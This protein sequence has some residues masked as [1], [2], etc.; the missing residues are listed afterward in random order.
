METLSE[1]DLSLIH[2]GHS[3]HCPEEQFMDQDF[4]I[5][6]SNFSAT[7]MVYPM[8]TSTLTSVF[9]KPP[10]HFSFRE[11]SHQ[12]GEAVVEALS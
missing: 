3:G 2:L 9:S 5:C 7:S 10:F 4:I 8:H 12:N 11:A 6:R 1:L